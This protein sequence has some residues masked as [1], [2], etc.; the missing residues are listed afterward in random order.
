MSTIRGEKKELIRQLMLAS[1][2]SAAGFAEC[3]EQDQKVSESFRGWIA[4]GN[5][6]GMHYLQLHAPLR[7]NPQSLLPEARTIISLAFNYNPGRPLNSGIA[8]Y[9]AGKDYHNVI[10]RLLKPAVRMLSEDFGAACRICIDSAPI[11]ERYWARKAGIGF[12]GRNG[13]LIVP[14]T[15]SFVFLAEV[16]TTLEIEPDREARGSC[17]N[18]RRCER[19]CPTGALSD[20]LI[21][22]RRCLSYLTIEHRGEFPPHTDLKNHLFGCDDCLAACPHNASAPQSEIARFSPSETVDTLSPRRMLDISPSQFDSI[23]AGSPLRR[24]GH[25]GLTRNALS[26]LKK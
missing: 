20:G 10:R 1:G 7:D 11:S 6:A 8:R 2:A 16:I 5:H 4:R 12:I 23:F 19:A 14:R 22:S 25:C 24:A 3:G 15:G 17:G 21:D 18:C 13:A 26:I 9:A